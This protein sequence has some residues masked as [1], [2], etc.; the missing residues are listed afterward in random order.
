[1]TP[2]DYQKHLTMVKLIVT[3]Q[4]IVELVDDLKGTPHFRHDVKFHAKNL[5]N[6]LLSIL[7][8]SY[9]FIDGKEEEEEVY[10]FVERGFRKLLDT[11][12]EEMY[13]SG[14]VSA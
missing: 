7:T 6:K 11:T 3:S 4:L 2:E 10:R 8:T 1:M 5:S 14:E 12:V 13:E 9:K